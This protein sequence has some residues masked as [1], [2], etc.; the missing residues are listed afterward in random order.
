MLIFNEELYK[1]SKNKPKYKFEGESAWSK[2]NGINS[3]N[4]ELKQNLGQKRNDFIPACLNDTFQVKVIWTRSH[5]LYKIG[6]TKKLEVTEFNPHAPKL[7]YLQE[8]EN[9][10]CFRGIS[11]AMFAS[12]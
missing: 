6:S 12:V 4:I 7:K 11:S 8:D 10:C 5:T 2:I 9:T 3:K 1:S